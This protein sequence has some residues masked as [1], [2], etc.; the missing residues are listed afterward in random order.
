MT[1][2]RC[3]HGAPVWTCIGTDERLDRAVRRVSAA[4]ADAPLDVAWAAAEAALPE[5]WSLLIG[6]QRRQGQPGWW[7][8]AIGAALGSSV[9]PEA[10]AY[11]PTPAAALLALAARLTDGDG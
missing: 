2:P 6:E 5:G 4:I 11:F 8:T 1:I 3:R 10:P 9:R 7:A